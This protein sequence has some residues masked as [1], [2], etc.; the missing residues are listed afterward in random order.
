MKQRPFFYLAG[1]S[2]FCLWFNTTL[3]L[4]FDEAY[5][6]LWSEHLAASYFDHPP[7][8]AWLLWLI[9]PFGQAEWVL[10]LP[11]LFCMAGCGFLLYRLAGRAFGEAV[12]ER[13]LILF[14]LLPLTQIGFLLAVPDAPL[15]LGW[16]VQ[17]AGQ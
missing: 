13:S 14:L 3:P 11:P 9:R 15:A 17:L 7:L 4:H 5:Y 2:I 16:H 1:M 12:A 8:I 6:W 10:R